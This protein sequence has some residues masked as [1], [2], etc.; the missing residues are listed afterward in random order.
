LGGVEKMLEENCQI[1]PSLRGRL[2]PPL[3][4]RIFSIR[5]LYLNG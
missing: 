5:A 2:K 1:Q 3:P 4:N